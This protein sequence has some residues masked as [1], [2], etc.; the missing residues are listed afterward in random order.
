MD[1]MDMNDAE[2]RLYQI[3]RRAASIYRAEGF[4]Q[5]ASRVE[6]GLEDGCY[7]FRVAEFFYD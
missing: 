4:E 6:A 1:P 7:G 2:W 3:R 5:F